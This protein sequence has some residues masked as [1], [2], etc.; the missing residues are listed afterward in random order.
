MLT[1]FL[2]EDTGDRLRAAP[3]FRLIGVLFKLLAPFVVALEHLSHHR[4]VFCFGDAEEFFAIA[5][6]I[7]LVVS[8]HWLR[9]LSP[10]ANR[11]EFKSQRLQPLALYL[12]LLDC[13]RVR[14][15]Q[16]V[17]VLLF[18]A[19]RPSLPCCASRCGGRL[20][21]TPYPFR[22]ALCFQTFLI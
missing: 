8:C 11:G 16:R 9:N 13:F 5:F 21:P 10:C 7:K 17:S 4:V 6:S 19:L 3:S 12:F 18:P 1:G 20:K 2:D 22:F 15:C 14:C